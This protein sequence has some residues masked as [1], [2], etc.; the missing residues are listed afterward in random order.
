MAGIRGYHSPWVRRVA[1]E[2]KWG[3]F[4]EDGNHVG[5][6]ETIPADTRDTRTLEPC[7]VCGQ[8][9]EKGKPSVRGLLAAEQSF[10][11]IS[12][13]STQPPAKGWHKSRN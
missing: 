3:E 6:G 9:V 11:R 7:M 13:G 4:K 1:T 2:K 8:P 12:R 5:G 10:D